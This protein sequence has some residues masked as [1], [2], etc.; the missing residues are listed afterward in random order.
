MKRVLSA[1]AALLVIIPAFG[2]DKEKAFKANRAETYPAKLTQGK[3]TVAVVPYARPDEI[4]QAFGKADLSRYGVLPVLVVIDNDGP[5]ALKVDLIAEYVTAGGKHLEATPA[6]EIMYLN[7]PKRP[8]GLDQ[9]R[10]PIPTRKAKNNLEAWE[11]TG[12]AFTAKMVPPGESVSG[13]VY[14]QTPKESGSR[15]YL[16]GLA[17]TATGRELIY[18]EIPLPTE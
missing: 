4:R 17:D 12:R 9:P 15:I 3:V 14:F 2:L 11:V 1:L 7:S 16:T 10:F 8:K 5:K 18:F 6:E 13:F